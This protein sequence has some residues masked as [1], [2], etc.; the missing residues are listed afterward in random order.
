MSKW[1]DLLLSRP[2]PN[3]VRNTQTGRILPCCWSDCTHPGSAEIYVP[4]R[5]TQPTF[6]GQ[7]ARAIFCCD[8]HRQYFVLQM[9]FGKMS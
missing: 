9:T 2:V 7:E 3:L 8:T 4:V 5:N 1:T 6:P